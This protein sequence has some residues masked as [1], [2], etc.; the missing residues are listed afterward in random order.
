V[1]VFAVGAVAVGAADD[2]VGFAEFEFEKGGVD[3]FGD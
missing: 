2:G 3:A 1:D